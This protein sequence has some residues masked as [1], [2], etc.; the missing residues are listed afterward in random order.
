M[1]ETVLEHVGRY[2][3]IGNR[4]LPKEGVA[5]MGCEV[6]DGLDMCTASAIAVH[7]VIC[8]YGV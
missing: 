3:P 8:V 4:R 5:H 7:A 1:R 2:I 6:V